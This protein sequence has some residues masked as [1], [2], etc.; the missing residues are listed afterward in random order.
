MPDLSQFSLEDRTAIVTGASS[1]IGQAISVALGRAGARVVGVSSSGDVEETTRQVKEAGGS[2]HSVTAD[3]A[4]PAAACEILSRTEEL[5]GRP[6]I[7]VNNAGIIRR[8]PSLEF[9]EEDWDAVMAVN[10]RAPF[11]LAQQ[12]ARKLVDARSPGKIV[13]IC[14][15]LSFQGGIL[16]PSYTASKSALAG[17]TRALANEWARFAINVNAIA[18]GYICSRANAALREDPVRSRQILARI[19]AGR[20]GNPEEIG[21]MAVFL[22]SHASD[23]CHGGIY[24]VDGGWL[25]Y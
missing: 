8:S 18:P 24:P 7:L 5:T 12:F 20:W 4:T 6:D 19:P 21:G 25:A 1:G 22:A 13:N 15:M 14:S 16:V 11:L 3:L 23:Y 2:F 17:L 10:L 9:S